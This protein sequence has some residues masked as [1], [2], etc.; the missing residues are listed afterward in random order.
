MAKI[1]FT[2]DSPVTFQFG[3]LITPGKL[4]QTLESTLPFSLSRALPAWGIGWAIHQWSIRPGKT[5]PKRSYLILFQV[6]ALGNF[7]IWSI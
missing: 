7:A 3:I 5:P 1:K 6:L 2:D 4:N